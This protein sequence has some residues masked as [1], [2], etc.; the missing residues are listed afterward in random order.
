MFEE[1]SHLIQQDETSA[2]LISLH[3]KSQRFVPAVHDVETLDGLAGRPLD[4]IVYCGHQNDPPS[5]R[6]E[7]PGD[8][9]T[10]R[11]DNVLDVRVSIRSQQSNEPFGAIGRLVHFFERVEWSAPSQDPHEWLL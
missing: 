8:F 7:P 3:S 10:I 5:S 9:Q 2:E 4:K 11:T 6:I 1:R